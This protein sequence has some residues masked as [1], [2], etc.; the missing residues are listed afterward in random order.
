MKNARGGGNT[1]H[2]RRPLNGRPDDASAC[3][4]RRATM[5]PSWGGLV[6]LLALTSPAFAAPMRCTTHHEKTLNRWQTLCDNG[7]RAT[8]TW[9]PTLRQWQTTV[10]PPPGKTCAGQVNPRTRQVEVR[11]R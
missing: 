1:W 10:T 2:A 4:K 11:C 7:I 3:R 5:R 8:S 6:L 9:S